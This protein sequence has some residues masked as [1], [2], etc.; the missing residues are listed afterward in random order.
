MS[1]P[2][3]YSYST[4]FVRTLQKYI[5]RLEDKEAHKCH[6]NTWTNHISPT[7][8]AIFTPLR[9]QWILHYST[10]FP[11]FLSIYSHRVLQSVS[12][13]LFRSS[14]DETWR[15]ENK[16][17]LRSWEVALWLWGGRCFS[18]VSCLLKL[19]ALNLRMRRTIALLQTLVLVLL[20]Q[21]K[22]RFRHSR[23]WNLQMLTWL[24]CDR[25]GMKTSCRFCDF[26]P[27]MFDCLSLVD[28]WKRYHVLRK[29]PKKKFIRSW[30]INHMSLGNVGNKTL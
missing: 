30:C 16:S 23:L 28:R 19:Q 10:R 4:L 27:A 11:T 8:P 24:S 20:L 1:S 29:T 3:T 2:P 26:C 21:V 14:G 6:C 18:R 12:S 25:F 13:I 22:P 15:E 17:F 7:P 5:R 9:L